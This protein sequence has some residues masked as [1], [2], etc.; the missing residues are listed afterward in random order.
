MRK[1]TLLRVRRNSI[2]SRYDA[3]DITVS[4]AVTQLLI[5][6]DS[7]HLETIERALVAE[8]LQSALREWKAREPGFAWIGL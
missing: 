6:P 2:G 4:Y 1:E 8:L 5:S 3:I 7:R